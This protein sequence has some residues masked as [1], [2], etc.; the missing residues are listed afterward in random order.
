MEPDERATVAAA[1]G[2]DEA[3]FETVI[4]SYSRRIYAVAYA[5]LQDKGDAEDAVQDTFLKAY[6]T[7]SRLREP[8]KVVSW[9]SMIA[10]NRAR[11]ILRKRRVCE[12]HEALGLEEAS[13]VADA[14]ELHLQ[15]RSVLSR[16][17]EP[18]RTAVTLRYMEDMDHRSIEQTMGLT[19]GALRGILGRAVA[20]MRKAMRGT[21]DLFG[22]GPE[23]Q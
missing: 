18:H 4:R 5:V 16:L 23:I 21:P 3:A 11:D 1:L 20:S 14:S 12:I 8:E 19:N 6:R 10:R 2:G 22:A 15:V 7:R 17:P 9:L 13:D